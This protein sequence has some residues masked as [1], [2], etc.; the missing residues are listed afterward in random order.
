MDTGRLAADPEPEAESP[1]ES[2][3]IAKPS[4]P[5]WGVAQLAFS[6]LAIYL[7]MRVMDV[8]I[9]GKND[10]LALIGLSVFVV[11]VTIIATAK[12]SEFVARHG[13]PSGTAVADAAFGDQFPVEIHLLVEGKQMGRDRGVLW[14][15]D[16]LMGFSG[17]A[18]S[19]VLAAID[20]APQWEKLMRKNTKKSYPQDAI[21]LRDAPRDAYFVVTP[22]AGR[23]KDYRK[24]LYEFKKANAVPAGERHWPPLH[25]Y[26]PDEAS[27]PEPLVRS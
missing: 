24:R 4:K 7:S 13:K 25:R 11:L 3:W 16:G 9:D 21:V 5:R 19:F 20:I 22:L 12:V 27:S 8:G 6:G 14:F 2:R 23:T 15:G 18:F 1:H 26:I 17:H 10:T